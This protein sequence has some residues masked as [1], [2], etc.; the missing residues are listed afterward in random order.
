MAS[1]LSKK[2]FFEDN[3]SQQKYALSE[4][5][6]E[7]SKGKA[8]FVASFDGPAGLTGLVIKGD[9]RSGKKRIAW[10][11]SGSD[12][13]IFGPVLDK[14][15]RDLTSLAAQTQIHSQGPGINSGSGIQT[16]EMGGFLIKKAVG[17]LVT[18]LYIV[19]SPSCPTCRNLL[20][21][22]EDSPVVFK[23]KVQVTIIPIGNTQQDLIQAAN[24]LETG[25]FDSKMGTRPSKKS[26]ATVAKNTQQLLAQTNSQIKTPM[27]LYEGEI[28]NSF[29]PFTVSL[30]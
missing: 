14:E 13:L 18:N 27:L 25:V 1:Y 28:I 9:N 29:A 23:D 6:S 30:K 2:N 24:L 16:Q 17:P 21:Q 10:H 26:M 4:L 22:L 11:I 20:T 3:A 15:G 7:V 12:F 19:V 8:V 5:I